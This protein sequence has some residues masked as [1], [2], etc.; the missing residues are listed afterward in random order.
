MSV[1]TGPTV[2]VQECNLKHQQGC[3]QQG[4][5][6]MSEQCENESVKSDVLQGVAVTVPTWNI[7]SYRTKQKRRN[8]ELKRYFWQIGHRG[9]WMCLPH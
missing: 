2:F 9:I 5:M 3:V 8:G 4:T 7:I 6:L 1:N